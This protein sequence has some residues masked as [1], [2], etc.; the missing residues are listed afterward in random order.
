ML[1]GTPKKLKSRNKRMNNV[2]AELTDKSNNGSV[3][4]SKKC[5]EEIASSLPKHL[6]GFAMET[7][8]KIPCWMEKEI[9]D[10]PHLRTG[11]IGLWTSLAEIVRSHPIL[12]SNDALIE[13]TS[14]FSLTSQEGFSL[15]LSRELQAW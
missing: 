5:H 1:A 7:E 13:P 9:S 2:N 15:L 6:L 10:L 3:S 14:P 4:A 12:L 11:S 8:G